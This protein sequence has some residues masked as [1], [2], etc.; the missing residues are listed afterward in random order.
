M[1]VRSEANQENAEGRG[2]FMPIKKGAPPTRW[3]GA[4]FGAALG[5]LVLLG[6]AFLNFLDDRIRNLLG[7]GIV[8]RELHGELATA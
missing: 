3:G 2:P 8:V 6:V 7:A 1:G 4:P 5:R